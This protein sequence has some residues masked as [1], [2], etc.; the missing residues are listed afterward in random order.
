MIHKRALIVLILMRQ[1]TCNRTQPKHKQ[2][3]RSEKR[4]QNNPLLKSYDCG[5]QLYDSNVECN[6][7]L[8]LELLC[9]ENHVFRI[10]SIKR[11]IEQEGKRRGRWGF[12][13]GSRLTG[14]IIAK[15]NAGIKK[16]NQTLTVVFI[17]ITCNLNTRIFFFSGRFSENVKN[18]VRKSIHFS[19]R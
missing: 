9:A 3:L 12:L 1:T 19:V 16:I 14:G 6:R 4:L 15:K 10:G 2:K 5:A 13:Y 11:Y 7:P 8:P 18:K 17:D